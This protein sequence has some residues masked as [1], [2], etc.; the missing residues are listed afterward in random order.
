M[1]LDDAIGKAEGL[2]QVL[3]DA[4]EQLATETSDTERDTAAPVLAEVPPP[5]DAEQVRTA[6]EGHDNTLPYKCPACG[7]TYEKPVE[8]TNGHPAEQT[9][10]TADVLAGAAPTAVTPE[11]PTPVA[12]QAVIETGKTPAAPAAAANP[13]WPD[14]TT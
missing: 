9:L 1:V 11:E 8:C 4:R 5:V 6:E 2:L 12:N 13:P 7:K 14:A 10:E 3:K